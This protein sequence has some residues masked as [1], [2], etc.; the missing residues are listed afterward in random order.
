MEIKNKDLERQLCDFTIE[1]TCNQLKILIKQASE[2]EKD[3]D[4]NLLKN[5]QQ[6]T[7]AYD[8][9]DEVEELEVD[10][11]LHN[12]KQDFLDALDKIKSSK[13]IIQ[14]ECYLGHLY[15]TYSNY[16]DKCGH[17]YDYLKRNNLC[18]YL[19][20]EITKFYNVSN[21]S[22]EYNK[23]KSIVGIWITTLNTFNCK[24]KEGV[25][26]EFHSQLEEI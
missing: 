14:K 9:I 22:D 24:N 2:N 12:K 8:Y 11:P 10:F 20:T 25:S 6:I 4:D 26:K 21:P 3:F 15:N 23:L 13:N 16:C 17:V 18:K 5:L 1:Y 19:L 7:F